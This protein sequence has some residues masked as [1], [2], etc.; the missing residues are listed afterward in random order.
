MVAKIINRNV[1][2]L[3]VVGPIY[4]QIDKLEKVNG[5]LNDYDYVIFNGSLCY[6]YNNLQQVEQRISRMNDLLKSYKVTYNVSQHDL[7]CAKHLY[8]NNQSPQILKWICPNPM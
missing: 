4:D 8:D 1:N 6:P 5:L 7:L 2:K 3:L